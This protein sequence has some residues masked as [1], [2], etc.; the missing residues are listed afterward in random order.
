FL[1]MN[2]RTL[3]RWLPALALLA[4]LSGCSMSPEITD[5]VRRGPFFTPTNHSGDPSL[6]GMRRVVLLPVCGG[7]LAPVETVAALDPVVTAALQ[8]QRRFE[9]VPISREQCRL[10]FHS[11]EFSSVAALPHDFLATLQHDFSA[12]GVI[13]VDITVFQAYRPL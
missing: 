1:P 4:L 6:G 13:F 5:P 7:T 3:S 9:V 11:E 8:E 10:K 12:D 2:T